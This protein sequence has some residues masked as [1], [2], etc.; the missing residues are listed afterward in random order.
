MWIAGISH[1]HSAYVKPEAGS[2]FKE[3]AKKIIPGELAG[4]NINLIAFIAH[5]EK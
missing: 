4:E 5:A 3:Q 2:T 1:T